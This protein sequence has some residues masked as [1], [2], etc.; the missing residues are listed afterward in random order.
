MPSAI[1]VNLV[2]EFDYVDFFWRILKFLGF[3]KFWK[4]NERRV[5]NFWKFEF[6]WRLIIFGKFEFS[7]FLK[8][9]IFW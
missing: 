6:F 9:L 4:N 3:S 5:L 8:E 7:N 2:Q 1:K